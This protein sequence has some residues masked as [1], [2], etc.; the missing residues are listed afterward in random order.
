MD[1]KKVQL[2]LMFAIVVVVYNIVLFLLA[3]V[4]HTSFW[5]SYAFIMFSIIMC[6]ISFFFVSNEKRKS[7]VVGMPVTVLSSLYL[8]IEFVMGTIF[9]FFD[10]AFA[11]V[12]VPQFVLCALYLLCFIPAIMSPKNYK[13]A[14]EELKKTQ[15][16]TDEVVT[17][18]T[19]SEQK[20]S[21]DKQET[22]KQEEEE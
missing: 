15:A 9:M 1:R 20:P 11:T 16:K 5:T 6:V 21:E 18:K 7:Q 14:R 4:F 17:I 10:V 2:S 19:E 8:A 13:T 3:G 22:S 12:F